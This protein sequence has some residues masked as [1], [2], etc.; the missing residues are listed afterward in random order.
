M[1]SNPYL[2][3]MVALGAISLVGGSILAFVALNAIQAGAESSSSIGWSVSLA[4]GPSIAG[5]GVTLLVI[6]WVIA[7]AKWQRP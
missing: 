1:K 4:V 5:F 6:A 3:P 2:P 7:A